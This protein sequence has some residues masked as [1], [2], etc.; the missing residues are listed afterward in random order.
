[1]LMEHRVETLANDLRQLASAH[2][3]TRERLVRLEVIIHE[4]RRSRDA[5]RRPPRE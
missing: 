2:S 5:A 1:M 3:E 4:A